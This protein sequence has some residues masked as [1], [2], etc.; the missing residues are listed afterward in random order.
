VNLGDGSRLEVDAVIAATGYSRGLEQLVGHLGVLNHD[1]TPEP[2]GGE[3]S[4]IAPG[5]YFIGYR[6]APGGLLRRIRI[7]AEA[8]ALTVSQA[9]AAAG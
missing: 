4:P 1:G 9:V 2:S 8:M 3:T 5:V 7:E 6:N